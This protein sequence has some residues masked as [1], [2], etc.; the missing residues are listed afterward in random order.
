[1]EFTKKIAEITGITPNQI[2][3]AITLLKDEATIPFIARYRKEATG[4]LD[5]VEITKI[6][7]KLNQLEEI[8]KRRQ[9]I[10]KS[11]IERDLLTDK[12][13]EAIDQVETMTSLEDIYLPFRPKKR[14]RASKAKEKG[15]EGLAKIIYKQGDIDPVKE[16]Q[17]Y[18]N[19]DKDVNSIEDAISGAQDIIA[20]WISENGNIRLKLRE[21]FTKEGELSSKVLTGKE[22]TGETYTDY[23]DWTEPVRQAPSHRI[24]AIFRGESESVLSVHILP[25]EDKALEIITKEIIC[26]NN[27]CSQIVEI[28]L[29]DS[30]KRLL[31]PAMENETRKSAKTRADSEAIRVFSE[32]LRELLMA[33]PLGQKTVM[34]IDP[35]FRTGC[36][37]VCLN[38]QGKLLTNTT[39]YPHSGD[40]Q[41]EKAT[42]IVK[43]YSKDN[44]TDVIAVGNGTASRETISFLNEIDLPTEIRIEMVNESGASIYSAS[45]VAREEFPNHDITV[46]GSVS[47]G[48]R[49][50][51]PLSELVKIDAKSIGVGQYQHDVDQSELKKGLDDII[52][53]CVNS[54]GVELNT[55]SKQL[56]TYVSGLGPQLAQNIIDYRNNNGPFPS[57]V[58]LKKVPR[59]GP[60]AFEQ[61]AGF[62]RII[63]SEN[64]LDRSAVH[65]ESYHIVKKMAKNNNCAI[66]DLMGN[67]ELRE[68]IILSDYIDEKVG[69]PTLTDIIDEL[70]QPGR[71][72]RVEFESFQYD[73]NVH[74]LD[75]L[76]IG[77][78]LPGI[79]TNVTAFGAFVDIGVHQ[80]GLVHISEIADEYVKNPSDFLK[81]HQ[82]VIVTVI[83]ID[84]PRKRIA[85]SLKEQ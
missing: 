85:L 14:T 7:D 37:V 29:K 60:K 55:A 41:R 40:T 1:M 82:K 27:K 18:I 59:L 17:K 56:L 53:S 21:L 54:I 62:L 33:P 76:K 38:R 80:D 30:Y 67:S 73:E 84:I 15:L 22:E 83:G 48:R 8:E 34:A 57:R 2:E 26:N 39:I 47:I 5:E 71:D 4:G 12:L 69:L 75:D 50:M 68:S 25:P 43:Q 10:L 52:I 66:N 28:A 70:K 79:I 42:K 77:M 19:P 81:V 23:F 16:A 20:E 36:K 45:E 31:S 6:R 3:A 24:L 32:N 51:D 64:I 49:L 9:A 35:G 63:D 11:L 65:P 78:K 13:K 72:P 58:N 44:D 61:S 74:S 46:R